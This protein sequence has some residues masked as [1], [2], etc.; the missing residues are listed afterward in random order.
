MTGNPY[1]EMARVFT[2]A[3]SGISLR[4]G[5]VT[6]VSPLTVNV[7]GLT[8]SGDALFCNAALLPEPQKAEIHLPGS[9]IDEPNGSIT[10]PESLKAGDRVLLYSDHDQ[11]FYILCKVV[12]T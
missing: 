6:G 2:S 5:I 10:F 11:V 3:E 1:S 4:F 12:S 9:Q 8:V 7:G